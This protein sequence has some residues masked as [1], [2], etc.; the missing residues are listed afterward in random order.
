MPVRLR[1]SGR[2]TGIAAVLSLLLLALNS[3][4]AFAQQAQIGIYSD[5]SRSSCSLSDAGG[6]QIRAYVVVNSVSGITGVRFSAPKPA[7][8]S[9][10]WVADE[11]PDGFVSIG[12]SQTDLSIA[13]G[14][15][16]SGPLHVVTM[17]FQKTSTTAP[18][19]QFQILPA[20]DQADVIF[21]DCS[22]LEHSL[23]KTDGYINGNE[24]CPCQTGLNQPP[25]APTAPYPA[26]NMINAPLPVMLTWQ[27]TDPENDPLHYDV[28]F[29]TAADPPVV[30]TDV[31]Q[32]S[33]D[34]GTLQYNTQYHWKVTAK[35]DHGNTTSGPL[36]T[37]TTS[38]EPGAPG[39]PVNPVPANNAINQ[40][41]KLSLRWQLSGGSGPVIN[42]EIHFG[43]TNT[44][45]AV[46]TIPGAANPIYD[47]SGL[48]LDSDYYWYVVSLGQNNKNT[49]GALWHF[50]TSTT[51][52]PPNMPAFPNPSAGAIGVSVTP[53]LHWQGS[54]PEG[55]PLEYDVYLGTDANPPFAAHT[56]TASY[57][58]SNLV[59]STM[60]RWRVVA[61]DPEN[62]STSGTTWTFT[63]R[64]VNP[65]TVPQLVSPALGS[66]VAPQQVQLSWTSTDPEGG[67]LTYDIYL[68]TTS[69]PPL[70]QSTFGLNGIKVNLLQASTYY[71]RIV[72]RDQD[73]QT[74]SG[75]E[76]NFKTSSP[77]LAPSS[78]DPPSGATGV[79]RAPTLTWQCSDPDNQPLHYTVTFAG[80]HYSTNVASFTPPAVLAAAT[81][82]Y[83]SVQALD[84]DNN[85]T[86]GP[87][88]HFTTTTAN[89]N[90]PTTPVVINPPDNAI[91][92]PG[93]VQ[94]EWSASDP[95]GYP[96][97]YDVYFGE[98]P[99]PPRV[100]FHA[101]PTT[102]MVNGLTSE[103]LYYW[104]IVA[105]DVD[106]NEVTGP[107][108][109]FTTAQNA[110][111]R[112]A[113]GLFADASG[114]SCS[115]ADKGAGLRDVYVVLN[116]PSTY[117]GVRFAAT[118]PACFNATWIAD[119][120]PYVTIGN[121]QSDVSIGFGEC[122]PAPVNCMKITYMSAGDTQGCCQYA[123]D[124]PIIIG[125]MLVT[126]CNFAELIPRSDPVLGISSDDACP[127]C[128][129]GGYLAVAETEDTCR[130]TGPHTLT[131]DLKLSAAADTHSGGIDVTMDSQLTFVSC[132]RGQMIADWGTFDYHVQQG[133]LT[134]N[135][136]GT[137][138]PAGTTGTFA[139]LTFTTDCC[140]WS[141]P[142][143]LGLSNAT[144]DFIV[145]QLI[146]GH[147]ECR[148]PPDGDVNNDGN[149]TVADAQCA[150][151]TYLYAP[152]DPPSDCGG[153][154]AAMR[155][156]VN[157]SATVTPADAN[158]IFRHWLDQSCSFCD[159]TPMVKVASGP[160]PHLTLRA[161]RENDDIVV[162]LHANGATP[163]SALGFEI[164]YPAGLD[165]VR[166]DPPRKDTFAAL[167]T[168]GVQTG[169]VR[170]GAYANAGKELAP[171]GDILAIRFH[172]GSGGVNGT[173]TA[174][175]FVDDLAGA[176]DVSTTLDNAASTPS[177][178]QVVL[179]QNTPNPFNPRTMIRFELPE[180]M[181][182]RLSIF[183]VHGRLVK[184]LLDERREAGA[185]MVEWDGTDSHAR[186]VATGV[187]FYVLDAGSSRYQHKMVLLK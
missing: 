155:A 26:Q 124:S 88:W 56:T 87:V 134:I 80:A 42:F 148:Y 174:L 100:A 116:G 110:L 161:V 81:I 160:A 54:D 71:W 8:F 151:E 176:Q 39:T 146:G 7:C 135:A 73:A 165:L 32:A 138:I 70:Y 180:P 72:A 4:H 178:N 95:E 3:F 21:T 92:Q 79:S 14:K 15:C 98:S 147:L 157:C 75:P 10:T 28:Y 25:S 131:V 159:G 111:P 13:T 78:P 86:D 119:T 77:P 63:T 84:S 139:R 76:W 182:V 123:L 109:K 122:L 115:L 183:D 162:V 136:S 150:L 62:A 69:P 149:V 108:W 121:S 91:R 16:L 43:T 170:V 163:I 117:T 140:S 164:K 128:A 1:S 118:K 11:V 185:S 142:A 133:V 105:R 49:Q 107:V 126:D 143:E 120:T 20:Q 144:G 166:V 153:P 152:L 46:A 184:Q 47:V 67:P 145:N 19:C 94:L 18:C 93:S 97:V 90:A 156:D 65:P 181:H 82:Y 68:G 169:R 167:E 31:P 55:E 112:L 125:K 57:S 34:P 132:E 158:C 29:G 168:R 27:T 127:A 45:P 37:F 52:P 24:T 59:E 60:Y 172:A 114:T 186:N 74:T 187:Y 130:A 89:G 104:R 53:V 40:L 179:H 41:R 177:E 85:S 2:T 99:T 103:T 171:D 141:K 38:I 129:K 50:H 102:Y 5:V 175:Q 33:Y 48:A 154:G 96:L 173:V 101:S 35:D 9:A 17:V 83:W 66:T 113:L 58:P 30:G 44:P 12:D 106:G 64:G 61:I 22:F 137:T 6:G 51:N 23:A 36:W